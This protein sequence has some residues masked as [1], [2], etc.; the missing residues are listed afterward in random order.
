MDSLLYTH[1]RQCRRQLQHRFVEAHIL[2]HLHPHH[3]HAQ[4]HR[5]IVL[6]LPERDAIHV[7]MRQRRT[8]RRIRGRRLREDVPRVQIA[9]G[10]E[11]ERCVGDLDVENVRWKS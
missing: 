4:R 8:G 11:G 10:G 5:R 9:I 2:E 7:E 6:H 1:S 3:E